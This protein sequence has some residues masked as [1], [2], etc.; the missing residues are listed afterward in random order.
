M[1]EARTILVTG[2]T[3]KQGRALIESLLGGETETE[4][5]PTYQVL[6]LTRHPSSA[7][8]RKLRERFGS[9]VTI[10]EGNLD[11]P[12]RL[13]QVFAEQRDHGSVWGVFAVLAYPG[14]GTN[15]ENE[16]KQGK[17]SAPSQGEWT[18]HPVN[19]SIFYLDAGRPCP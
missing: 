17:V 15:S 4:A 5:S 11:D 14:L 16:E 12:D 7:P 2:A 13:R 8:A 19:L 3:G 6:A 9:R 1:T 10:T 18:I